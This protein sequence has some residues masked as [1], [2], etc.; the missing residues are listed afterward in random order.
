MAEAALHPAEPRAVVAPDAPHWGLLGAF[1]GAK[2]VLHLA[3]VEGY[4]VFRDELYYLASTDHLAWGYVDHPPLSIV[5]LAAVESVFGD[6]LL[7]VR[8]VP[9]VA[10]ALTVGLVGWLAARLGGGAFAQAL[11]MLGALIAPVYLFLHHVYSMNAL[12][13]LLWTAA[14]GLVVLILQGGDRRLW[15]ALG[16]VL[17]LGLL[18][19]WSALWLGGGLFL[20][21]VLTPERRRLATPWPWAAAGTAL[22]LFLPNLLWQHAHGW[23]TLE[24][25]ANATGEKMAAVAPLDFLG[26]QVLGMHPLN[27]LLWAP[28]LVL[29]LA[30]PLGRPVRPLGVAVAAVFALLAFSGSSRVAY[31]APLYPVLFAAGALLWER[32]LRGRLR[33]ARPAL[34]VLLAAGFA[35]APFTL[36]VLPVETFVRYQAALGMEP[37]TEERKAIGALPQ[38]Y[39]D[40][41]GWTG[42]VDEVER[43]YRA[44]PLEEQ[45]AAVV[46]AQNYGEAGAIDV[47]G[48]ARGLPPAISGHNSYWT[49]GPRGASGEV[50]LIVG[51]D[52]ADNRAA[53]E[54]LEVVGRA[55]CRYC[56]PYEDD[57]PIS[58]CRGVRGSLED[59]WPALRH[60]D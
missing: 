2:L 15:L 8:T 24:F 44:L 55:D 36:P 1:A 13:L 23:P 5:L 40:M 49:W 45:A 31:A 50:V 35:L 37:G 47:L 30:L 34:L 32:G 19:K 57:L 29:L 58:V 21:L 56:M 18:N 11:A 51:G 48:R 43:A 52:E 10:G 38:H 60:Y 27:V 25:M 14:V 42:L 26:G 53:C 17:G 20:G 39:A 54:E 7:A 59:V 28:G 4:G 3:F 6:G 9:A 16:V 22:L 33:R 46:F 12:D 41:F